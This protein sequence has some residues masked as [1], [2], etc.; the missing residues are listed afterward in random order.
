MSKS[1]SHG[2]SKSMNKKMS[3]VMR[4]IDYNAYRGLKLSSEASENHKIDRKEL[5]RTQLHSANGSV[6]F[7]FGLTEERFRWQT[8]KNLG[9]QKELTGKMVRRYSDMSSTCDWESL[10]QKTQDLQDTIHVSK[11][12]ASSYKFSVERNSKRTIL[13]EYEAEATENLENK[14]KSTNHFKKSSA[15]G[16]ISDLIDKTPLVEGKYKKFSGKH[17][18]SNDIFTPLLTEN[19][20]KMSVPVN[21]EKIKQD[22]SNA[23]NFRQ[24]HDESLKEASLK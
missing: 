1:Q 20:M 5:V 21:L 18:E 7:P 6:R 15:I 9:E 8:N 10:I 23:G 2:A 13:P 17:L 24:V 22:G 19:K 11:N 14:K 4:N 16:G 3:L 12:R